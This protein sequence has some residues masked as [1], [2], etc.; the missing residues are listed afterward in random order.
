MRIYNC[1][2]CGRPIPPGYGLMYVRVDGVVLRFC[3]RKCFV[4]MVKMG[5]N[6]QKQAWVRKV[7]HGKSTVQP[8]PSTK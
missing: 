1:S 4:S 2:Y 6:P 7:R 5:R 3:S 8:K